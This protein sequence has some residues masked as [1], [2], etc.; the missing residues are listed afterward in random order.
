MVTDNATTTATT[1]TINVTNNQEGNLIAV[2]VEEDA[3]LTEYEGSFIITSGAD[4]VE[5]LHMEHGQT[6]TISANLQGEGSEA[7]QQITAD[8]GITQFL[9]IIWTYSDPNRTVEATE[10]GDGDTVYIKVSDSQTRGGIKTITVEN[11][12]IGN[13]ISCLL[14]TS[15]SPRDRS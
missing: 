1:K 2:S 9:D 3:T 8:Y 6:A 5:T 7:T 11:N 15:P 10:F 13:S 4:G 12:K 14:Y